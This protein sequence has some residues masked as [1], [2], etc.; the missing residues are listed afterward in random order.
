MWR[1]HLSGAVLLICTALL[2]S[3]CH[4]Q[5]AGKPLSIFSD[6]VRVAGL[7]AVDGYSGLRPGGPRLV[8]AADGSNDGEIDEIARQGVTDVE[9]FWEKTYQEVFT[10]S[11]LQVQ[12][13]M[14]W[15]ATE[16]PGD[17]FCRHRTYRFINA[18][19]CPLD[20]SIGWDR[21]VLMPAVRKAYG[22]MAVV[23][24]LAHEYG[25]ALSHM[26][27]LNQ[28]RA[29]TLVW[30]Q[31]ADCLAGVY[32]RWV[33]EDNSPR[34]ILSTGSGLNALLA[35]TVSI[36]DPLLT[37]GEQLPGEHGSAFE[38]ISAIQFGFREGAKTCAAIDEK[39]IE[40]RRSKLPVQLEL[41]QNGEWPVTEESVRIMTGEMN[42][43]FK[44][45]EEP[46]LS[47]DAA[48]AAVCTDARLSP[49]TS[50]CPATNTI[51]VDLP[52]LQKMGAPPSPDD[53]T[54]IDAA[55]GSGLSS[56]GDNTAYSALISRY[57]L[58][59]QQQRGDVALDSGAAGLRTACMT[60]VATTMM[61]TKYTTPEGATL[62]LTA[63]DLDEAVVGL[64]TNGLVASDVNGVAAPAGF[65]RI[66]AFRAGVLGTMD[67]CFKRYP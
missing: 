20:Y 2:I 43:L 28:D 26:A 23:M 3:S 32:L 12:R 67:R 42:A 62:S 18:A 9:S 58:A 19:F 21:G 4:K 60:G 66:D 17:R 61:A 8:V 34:F 25:H 59:L 54:T 63:G 5:M 41:D 37:E 24:V 50:Y 36:R 22:D 27:R 45:A 1:R 51:T 49:P 53:F 7:I 44:P 15:D 31:Q 55:V 47:F 56:T 30:E 11:F 14:S 39:Q 57:M 10:G 40:D 65:S 46:R 16:R 33:A 38:R 29:A 13:L 48:R 52:A 35:A 6:P 64:L